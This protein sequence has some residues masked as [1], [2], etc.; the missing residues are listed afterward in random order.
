[1]SKIDKSNIGSR[2]SFGPI[3]RFG[4]TLDNLRLLD[5]LVPENLSF[6]IGFALMRANYTGPCMRI[7]RV[8]DNVQADVYF[9]ASGKM[10]MDSRTRAVSN[11]A[12]NTLGNFANG[13]NC[14]VV[15]HYDQGPY[16]I[17][18]QPMPDDQQPL[19]ISNG[20]F[21]TN[22]GSPPLVAY[23]GSSNY[24][25]YRYIRTRPGSLIIQGSQPGIASGG[26]QPRTIDGAVSGYTQFSAAAIFPALDGTAPAMFAGL[27]LKQSG[28]SDQ[29]NRYRIF[30]AQFN[31]T[32]SALFQDGVR[33][34]LGD[35]GADPAMNLMLGKHTDGGYSN[36]SYSS[37]IST[38]EIAHD[39][40]ALANALKV[41]Y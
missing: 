4:V 15:E 37:V 28:N 7:R 39:P 6:A 34:A 22:D 5:R 32:Q 17:R 33:I 18:V 38:R 19:V 26:G 31:S 10:A 30:E 41:V 11:G 29:R 12:T 8:A 20:A 27:A 16:A 23:D 25:E 35:A 40:L 14:T 9:N 1:M 13:G 3:S 36:T 2:I 24:T 21:I